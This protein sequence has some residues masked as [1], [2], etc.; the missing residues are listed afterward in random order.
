[1]RSFRAIQTRSRLLALEERRSARSRTL[2]SAVV[3]ILVLA[4]S[5]QLA[6]ATGIELPV[7]VPVRLLVLSGKLP[8]LPAQKCLF[9]SLNQRLT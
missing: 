9:P 5:T 4:H 6:M 2:S 1:M 7:P 8:R 3:T